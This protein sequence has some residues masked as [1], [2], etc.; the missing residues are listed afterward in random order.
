ME[1]KIP[2]Q[3]G[4]FKVI[5]QKG[6]DLI[7]NFASK[8]RIAQLALTESFELRQRKDKAELVKLQKIRF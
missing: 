5:E 1:L 2:P 7:L 6:D 4:Y 8:S 3:S